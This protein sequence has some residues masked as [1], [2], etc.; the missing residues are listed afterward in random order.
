MADHDSTVDEKR[1]AKL[2]YH[3]AYYAANRER[4]LLQCK[5]YRLRN[6]EAKRV[7]DKAYYERTKQERARY[8]RTP[9]ALATRQKY[10]K[11]HA[12]QLREQH[13]AWRDKNRDHLRQYKRNRHRDPVVALMKRARDRT[14][15]AL[16][17]GLTKKCRRTVELLGCTPSELVLWIES[18][19]CDG[20][21]WER[22]SEIHLDHII[23]LAAFD[24]TDEDQQ[25]AAFHYTNLRPMWEIDNKRKSCRV[26]GQNLFGFAYA[27]KIAKGMAASRTRDT[28]NATRKYRRNMPDGVPQ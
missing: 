5:E 23:P 8:A 20:M 28:K 9:A 24:L 16:A 4:L 11:S 15:N 2:A 25:R 14:R 13:R 1:E 27:D 22:L 3:R 19:F 6:K 17:A 10:R 21:C 26:V 18:Q 7:R 12:D